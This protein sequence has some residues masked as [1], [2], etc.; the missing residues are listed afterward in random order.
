MSQIVSAIYADGVL[1]PTTPLNLPELTKVEVEV[2]Q[3][4]E[5]AACNDERKQVIEA[6][7]KAG[8]LANKPSLFPFPDDPISE[9]E[10]EELAMIFAGEKPLS[11]IIIE[12]RREGW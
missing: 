10:Q 5:L 3:P 8:L 1:R 11:E 9:E 12:E 6:L 7:T 4:P 2:R